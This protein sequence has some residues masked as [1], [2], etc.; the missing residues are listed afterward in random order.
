MH[1]PT[2]PVFRSRIRRR[3]KTGELALAARSRF[4]FGLWIGRKFTFRTR[5]YSYMRL[6]LGYSRGTKAGGP[7]G[8]PAL[9][10]FDAALF[11]FDLGAGVFQ[12]LLRGFGVGLG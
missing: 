2:M 11:H 9:H 3:R 7:S 8:P 4:V 1:H 10:D 6:F 12:L 5:K